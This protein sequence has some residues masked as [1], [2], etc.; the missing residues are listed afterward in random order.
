MIRG[1][2]IVATALWILCVTPVALA[3]PPT[4]GSVD[5]RIRT[6]MYDPDRVVPLNAF[7]GYQTMI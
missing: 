2:M 3:A 7:F 6:L 4:G 1:P 5:A